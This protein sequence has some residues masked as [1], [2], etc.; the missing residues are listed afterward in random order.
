MAYLF[1]RFIRSAGI[2]KARH[3]P[4]DYGAYCNTAARTALLM[5]RASHANVP[6]D[7]EIACLVQR[8]LGGDTAAF[9]EI[10]IRYERRVFTFAMKLLGGSDDAQDAAQ[11]VFLR[12]FKY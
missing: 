10:I 2:T 8:T 9:E 11:E 1:Q 5:A 7:A 6:P 4:M 3:E 12:A